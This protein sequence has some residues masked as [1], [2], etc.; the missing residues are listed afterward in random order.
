[1][2]IDIFKKLIHRITTIDHIIHN[3][4]VNHQNKAFKTVF[5]IITMFGYGIV[6]VFLYTIIYFTGTSAVKSLIVTI[7]VAEFVGLLIIILLR[8]TVT[9]P[10]PKPHVRQSMDYPWHDKSF[11][12]HHALRASILATG[13][14]LNYSSAIP[15]LI[16]M[17]VL[18]LLSRLYL[19]KH[20]LS[21]VLTGTVIG[22]ICLLLASKY[23]VFYTG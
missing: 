22:F 1:M 2:I 18:I 14:G 6:W 19:Q 11:P 8:N 17:L 12:S 9:R 21:D 13:F 15:L 4:V 10:R 7:V 23:A 3:W 5:Q 16:C 20:Y